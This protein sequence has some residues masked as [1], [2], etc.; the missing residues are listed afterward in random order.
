MIKLHVQLP[1]VFAAALIVFPTCASAWQ[2]KPPATTC[3]FTRDGYQG[4]CRVEPGEGETCESILAYLNSPHTVGK[5]YCGRTR[6]RTRWSL[7]DCEEATKKQT[8]QSRPA[9]RV[10]TRSID[11][12]L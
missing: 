3:C 9:R 10:G 2:E 8:E 1:A 6:L 4:V 7:V 11:G 12:R 5:A